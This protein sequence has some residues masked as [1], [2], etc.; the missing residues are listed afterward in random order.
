MVGTGKDH[1]VCNNMRELWVASGARMG[2]KAKVVCP[3]GEALC[4]LQRVYH[5]LLRTRPLSLFMFGGNSFSPPSSMMQ[6]VCWDLLENSVSVQE[7]L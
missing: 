5:D 3:H 2:H 6:A 4:F 7:L 1:R